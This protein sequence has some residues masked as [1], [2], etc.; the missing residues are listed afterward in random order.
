VGFSAGFWALSVNGNASATT[1][2]TARS[3]PRII[4]IAVLSSETTVTV[5]RESKE[6]NGV[7]FLM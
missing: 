4:V 7:S 3:L 2:P 6:E 1:S 5:R